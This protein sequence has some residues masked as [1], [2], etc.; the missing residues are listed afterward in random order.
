M[1]GM[2]ESCDQFVTIMGTNCR[3]FSLIDTNTKKPEA[4]LNQ[5]L[6]HLDGLSKWWVMGF[7]NRG[8][9]VRVLPGAPTS[10]TLFWKSLHVYPDCYP[11]QT[12]RNAS[13]ERMQEPP[14]IR[15]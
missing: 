9:R 6:A 10:E 11:G 15:Q 12:E 7:L 8:P 4:S 13:P 14:R 1:V 2:G 5:E 3:K